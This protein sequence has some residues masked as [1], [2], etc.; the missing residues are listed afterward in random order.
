M[1]TTFASAH[2]RV[3]SEE[4]KVAARWAVGI[5]S[6]RES[7]AAL[8]QTILAVR[9]ACGGVESLVD[10]LI[11]G[12]GALAEAIARRAV[13]E[14]E[15]SKAPAQIRVWAF[16]AA[17]KATTWNLFVHRLLPVV[18]VAYFVDGYAEPEVTSFAHLARALE[19]NERAHAA[20]GVPSMGPSA[21]RLRTTMSETGGLHGNQ[22][23]LRGSCV[24]RLRECRFRLPAGL[25]RTDGVLSAALYFDLNPGSNT[26]DTGRIAIVPE[27]TWRYDTPSLWRLRDWSA[28]VKRRLRQAQGHAENLAVR[29]MLAIER[30][31]V[32][33]LPPTTRELIQN[34]CSAAPREAYALFLRHPLTWIRCR[35]LLS[36]PQPNPGADQ[37]QM[38]YA[39]RGPA[40]PSTA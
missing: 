5:F 29:R 3:A 22:Y 17:D 23:A 35:Q 7:P 26:W 15:T 33:S 27:A 6:S 18:E 8:W 19:R 21:R 39:S 37:P 9:D 31:P 25:Y 4:G 36:G 34:W 1:D 20:A 38:L 30:R 12:N 28:F 40:D 16:K 13:R 14:W 24:T 2:M 32:D 11:N 10:V